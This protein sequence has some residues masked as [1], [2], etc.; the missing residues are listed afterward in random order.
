[1]NTPFLRLSIFLLLLA[2]NLSSQD[3]KPQDAKPA[4]DF[5]D[6]KY[7]PHERNVFDFWKAKSDKP[8]PLVLYI[9]GGGFKG[10][11][12]KTLSGRLLKEY[13][14]LGYSVAA[15][16]YRF[17]NVAPA[18]AQYLDCGRALQFI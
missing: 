14:E 15:F 18:P 12:K 6:V 11:D 7:G 5:A 4:P 8:T 2:G 3:G 16:N 10:G 17:T 13:L 9:H 1:M